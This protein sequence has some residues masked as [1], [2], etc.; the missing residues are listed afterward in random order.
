ME[1]HMFMQ[2]Q[3]DRKIAYRFTLMQSH[4]CLDKAYRKV[5]A[6]YTCT[7]FVDKFCSTD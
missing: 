6:S 5:Q 3:H 4:P 1:N 2:L 7:I